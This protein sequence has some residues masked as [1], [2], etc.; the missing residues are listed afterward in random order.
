VSHAAGTELVYEFIEQYWAP[1]TTSADLLVGL[2]GQ[3]QSGN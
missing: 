1:S 3:G 2:R